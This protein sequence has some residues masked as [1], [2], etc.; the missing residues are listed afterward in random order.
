M[1]IL[2]Y[3]HPWLGRLDA[4][5]VR[6]IVETEN[7]RVNARCFTEQKQKTNEQNRMGSGYRMPLA[8]INQ[9]RGGRGNRSPA[10]PARNLALLRAE[11]Q[12]KRD[13]L[14]PRANFQNPVTSF[15]EHHHISIEQPG[16]KQTPLNR[17]S[18][19]EL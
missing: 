10:F 2:V 3:S 6:F 19:S 8:K 11:P 9:K 4:V 14:P 12:A 13:W 15:D 18:N 17:R 1:W 16:P 5:E 7:K